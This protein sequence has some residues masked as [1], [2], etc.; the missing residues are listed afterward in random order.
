MRGVEATNG[1]EVA[2]KKSRV[3]LRVQRTLLKHEARVLQIIQGH[4]SVPSLY[5]YGRFP[6]FEYLALELCGESIRSI[7]DQGAGVLLKTVLIIAKQMACVLTKMSSLSNS[8]FRFPLYS[9]FTHAG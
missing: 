3:S 1:T 2:V 6:H 4:A 5:A 9:I 7:P 8:G